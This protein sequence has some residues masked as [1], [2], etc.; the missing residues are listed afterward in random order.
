MEFL[1]AFL[2]IMLYIVTIILVIIL[3]VLAIKAIETLER[4]NK[5]ADNVEG[6][7]ESLNG[8]FS[9]VDTI[10]DKVS[11]MSDTLVSLV[12]NAI[13]KVFRRKRKENDTNGE[14]E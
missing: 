4:A 11:L 8:F 9:I 13:C 3:I 1:A 12:S 7:L 2:P 5:I 10:T 14:E 6:K